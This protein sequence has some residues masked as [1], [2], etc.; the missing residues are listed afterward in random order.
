MI[1]IVKHKYDS[2]VT[3]TNGMS[4]DS[5]NRTCTFN[6]TNG[7]TDR[8]YP[9]WTPNCKL[10]SFIFEFDLISNSSSTSFERVDMQFIK[11]RN[12]GAK[13]VILTQLDFNINDSKLT[14]WPYTNYQSITAISQDSS[15][16]VRAL[17]IDLEQGKLLFYRKGTKVLEYTLL[18]SFINDTKTCNKIG[19]M[20]FPLYARAV[21]KIKFNFGENGFS[22]NYGNLPALGKFLFIKILIK[23]TLLYIKLMHKIL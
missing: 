14:Q 15:T 11:V 12:S 6:I 21:C 19:F 2:N 1:T 10:S 23:I 13:K 5:D 22:Y 17:G 18:S 7:L 20:S 9:G 4:L 16:G 3:N 8:V